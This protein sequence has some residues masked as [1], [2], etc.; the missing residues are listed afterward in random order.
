MRRLDFAPEARADLLDIAGYIARDDPER[1]RSFVT[2]LE[3]RCAD[4]L[5]NPG[6]GRDRS[7]LAL[8]LRSKPHGSYLI[9]YT[10]GDALVRIERILHGARDLEAVFGSKTGG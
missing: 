2:E 10:P 1:A 9:F 7:E 5:A 4:L 8:N 6:S 3:R